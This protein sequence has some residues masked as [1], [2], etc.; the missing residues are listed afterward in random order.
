MLIKFIPNIKLEFLFK[1]SA[2]APFTV[3]IDEHPLRIIEVEGEHMQPRIFN[4][5]NIAVGQRYSVI[6]NCDKDVKNFW[7]RATI[8]KECIHTSE[9]TINHDSA[10]NYE[11][12]GIL[13][14]SGAPEQDPTTA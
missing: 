14:Y 4:K 7:I 1:F 10:L 6:V 9:S 8:V 11:I 13:R 12:V 5:I 2:E 3:S